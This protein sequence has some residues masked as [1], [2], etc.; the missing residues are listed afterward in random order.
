[1]DNRSGTTH[2]YGQRVNANG[3]LGGG[4]TD[5]PGNEPGTPGV[6]RLH[7][8]YPNP[9]NPATTFTFS[10]PRAGNALLNIYDMLGQE[11]ATV[12]NETLPA[13]D[14]SRTFNAAGLASGAYFYRLTVAEF[15]ETKRMMLLK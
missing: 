5:V 13:G 8:S 11:V 4:T 2:I 15:S 6:F 12:V 3:T 14:Y 9:F 7:Q 1:L 10:I